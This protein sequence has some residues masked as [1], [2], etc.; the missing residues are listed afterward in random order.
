MNARS[1]SPASARTTLTPARPTS[2]TAWTTGF[3]Q[4]SD[5]LGFSG[6]V[7]AER[8]TFRQGFFRFKSDGSRARVPPQHEQQLVGGRHQ[9]GGHPLRLDGQR[10]PERLHADRQPLLRVSARHGRRAV[11]QNIADSNRFFPVTDKVR[12]VDWHGGYTAAAGHALHRPGLSEGL[13]EPDS[14]R[15]RTDRPS[16]RARSLCSKTAATSTRHNAWNLWPATTSGP[17]RSWQRS[18]LTARSG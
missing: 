9:R 17:R 7:G 14:V 13:L 18:V 11:L 5:M 4:S 15:R 3:M 8:H 2:A 1:S 12:Q 16:G 10:L 6:R